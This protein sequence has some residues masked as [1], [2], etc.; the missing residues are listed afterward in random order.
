MKKKDARYFA[1]LQIVEAVIWYQ[2]NVSKRGLKL[3]KDPLPLF[4]LYTKELKI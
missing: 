1:S 2:L 4:L 3:M